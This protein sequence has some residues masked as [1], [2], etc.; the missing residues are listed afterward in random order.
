MTQRVAIVQRPAKLHDLAASLDIAAAAIAEAAGGGAG[1]VVFPETW[2]TGYP[3]WSFSS[4]SWGNRRAR[5]LYAAMLRE[6][7]VVPDDIGP[8][9]EAASAHDVSVVIGVNERSQPGSGTLYNSLVTVGP[10][11]EVLNVHRKLVPTHA[12][13]IVW[14]PGDAAGLRAVDLPVGRVGGLICWEHWNPLA[15]AA[16]HA[17]YEQIHVAVW[18]DLTEEH[19]LAARN[20]AF[21]GRCFVVAAGLL[22]PFEAVPE[23]MREEY[24]AA[25]GEGAAVGPGEHYFTGN[26]AV[27]GPEGE[28]VLEPQDGV[29][30]IVYA[31]VDLDR[32]P[33]LHLDLDATGHY[34]R[35]DVLRLTVDRRRLGTVEQSEHAT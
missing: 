28:W 11:G 15:R 16:L 12:E 18:P 10:D 4:T 27:I 5:E 29:D 21:E 8:V 1:L 3:G 31:D 17:D 25:L 34:A 6:S 24:S 13:K 2:L 26:S 35:P 32:L 30:G 9:R 14:A 7:V 33:G 22:L 23:D 20:H 19:L